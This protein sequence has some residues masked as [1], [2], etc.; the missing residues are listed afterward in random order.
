MNRNENCDSLTTKVDDK[1]NNLA[2]LISWARQDFIVQD[3]TSIQYQVNKLIKVAESL[4]QI[5][6]QNLDKI[7]SGDIY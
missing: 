3:A 4:R 7:E 1:L 2:L 6:I 5:I